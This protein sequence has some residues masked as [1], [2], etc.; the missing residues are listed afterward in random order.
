MVSGYDP[1]APVAAGDIA[2]GKV[3]VIAVNTFGPGNGGT[4]VINTPL[5]DVNNFARVQS[6]TYGANS[7]LGGSMTFNVGAL[8][9]SGG[10]QISTDTRGSGAGGEI[11]VA[12]G[13]GINISG[14]DSG[15][16]ANSVFNQHRQSRQQRQHHG[17]REFAFHCERR[18]YIRADGNRWRRRQNINHHPGSHHVVIRWADRRPQHRCW[19]RRPDIYRCRQHAHGGQRANHHA[20]DP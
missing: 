20:G 2:P 12:A 19:K 16:F 8:S 10:G 9:L 6:Q 4:L 13:G 11:K 7:G 18:R 14:T 1:N 5:L 15:L 17:I 3:S